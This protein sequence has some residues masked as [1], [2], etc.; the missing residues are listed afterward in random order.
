MDIG[1]VDDN[2]AHDAALPAGSPVS[3]E[4]YPDM[5][6][7]PNQRFSTE[8]LMAAGHDLQKLP[9]AIYAAWAP[10]RPLVAIIGLVALFGGCVTRGTHT[11]AIVFNFLNNLTVHM[12]SCGENAFEPAPPSENRSFP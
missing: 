10:V 8:A 2:I 6:W 9:C 5:L 11:K 4:P 12:A 1:N 7:H 3:H